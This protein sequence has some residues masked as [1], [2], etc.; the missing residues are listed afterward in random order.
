VA[1]VVFGLCHAI[2]DRRLLPF[3]LWAVWEGALL[4][5]VYVLSGSLL[6]VVVLHILHDIA[7]FSVFAYQRRR[8]ANESGGLAEASGSIS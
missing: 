3:T 7:G 1:A 4:G 8:W 2:P 6:V 5:G